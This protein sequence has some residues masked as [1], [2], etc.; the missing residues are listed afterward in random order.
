VEASVMLAL[1]PDLVKM[2]RSKDESGDDQKRS[3]LPREIRPAIA[4]YASFPN[5]YSGDARKATAELGEF[6]LEEYSKR[7]SELI[8]AVKTDETT[9]R[10]QDEFFKE[11]QSPLETKAR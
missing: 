9:L 6:A 5:H 8:K 4:W 3:P 11:S 1:R 7:L 10:L 2:D